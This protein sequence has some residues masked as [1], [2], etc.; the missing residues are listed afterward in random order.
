M[1][2]EDDNKLSPV[3]RVYHFDGYLSQ[4]Q[5]INEENRLKV[6]IVFIRALGGK[7]KNKFLF[8][9]LPQNNEIVRSLT[10]LYWL[11]SNLCLEFPYTYVD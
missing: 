2:K 10:D 1:I 3:S 6:N 4:F 5:T 8:R 7:Q 9:V 11:R